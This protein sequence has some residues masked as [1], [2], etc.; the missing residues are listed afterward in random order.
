MR[1]VHAV[2]AAAI[3][4]L[5]FGSNPALA[6]TTLPSADEAQRVIAQ[7][8]NARAVTTLLCPSMK[9]N[10]SS[11]SGPVVDY[12][13]KSQFG[14]VTIDGQ[15][16]NLRRTGRMVVAKAT[17]DWERARKAVDPQPGAFAKLSAAPRD[18]TRL[19]LGLYTVGTVS[20]IRAGDAD[21][22]ALA[23]Y[24]FTISPTSLG[25]ALIK[26]KYDPRVDPDALVAVPP[27]AVFLS[28]YFDRPQPL[29]AVA[30]LVFDG[31][32]HVV[33]AP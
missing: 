19:P 5:V 22:T 10:S 17:D 26:Q 1:I 28:Y 20:N 8:V 3:G 11:G 24:T 21:Q 23:D 33:A 31:T 15:E 32:W 9:S 2:R 25:D 29:T 18:C 27:R 14:L 7:A 12:L 30:K 4:A 6:A 16:F 13:Q